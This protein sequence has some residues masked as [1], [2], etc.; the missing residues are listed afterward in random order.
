MALVGLAITSPRSAT[1]SDWTPGLEPPRCGTDDW[2]GRAGL[3]LGPRYFF[4]RKDQVQFGFGIDGQVRLVGPLSVGASVTAGVIKDTTLTAL[5]G[6][7]LHL[8]RSCK[9]SL[10][11][12]VMT[13][14]W[15]LLD[16]DGTMVE[17]VV[18]GGLELS[19]DLG[20]SFVVRVRPAVGYL[21]GDGRGWFLD[22]VIGLGMLL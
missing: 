11:L 19:H 4:E 2:T 6:G 12:E 8:L 16:G 3:H 20:E 21:P 14:A 5:G 13:G 10:A 7:R 1:G 22:V 17:P 15:L 9:L 18:L